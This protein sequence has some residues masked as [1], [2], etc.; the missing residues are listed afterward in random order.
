[1][2]EVEDPV[3]YFAYVHIGKNPSPTLLKFA[4]NLHLR[5]PESQLILIT[6][7]VE[8]WSSFPGI[9][10][11]YSRNM[12]QPGV[13][14]FLAKR[15]EYADI[16]NGYWL[17]TLER[18]LALAQLNEIALTEAPIIHLES[19]VAI[20]LTKDLLNSLKPQ[21]SKTALPRFSDDYG[22]GSIVYFPNKNHLTEFIYSINIELKGKHEIENDMELLGILLNKSLVEELPSGRLESSEIELNWQDHEIVFDGAAIGQY[23]LGQ[24]PLHTGNHRIS[25]YQNPNFPQQLSEEIWKII[26]ISK[27][28]FLS[29]GVDGNERLVLGLHVHAKVPLEPISMA[30]PTWKQIIEEA[31]QIVTRKMGDFTPDLIHGKKISFKNRVRIARRNGLIQT[32]K[33]KVRN[34]VK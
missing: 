10:L 25:G 27:N 11:E 19:D 18:F 5:F 6:D 17:F 9:L 16:S 28:D 12:R 22:V 29:Y 23:L 13:R 4:R 1:M 3:A 26:R 20:F 2:I 7:R 31:N 24:D 8:D 14:N 32:L 21:L 15:R 30:D 34:L 33:R